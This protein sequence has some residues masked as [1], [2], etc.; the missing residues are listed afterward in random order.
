MVSFSVGMTFIYG[1]ISAGFAF[2]AIVWFFGI[3]AAL[4]DLGE[5]IAADSMDMQGDLLI[6]SNSIAIRYG[7]QAALRLSG[8]I[9]LM[10]IL[11]LFVPFLI[12]WFRIVHLMPIMIMISAIGYSA[13]RLLRS[14]NEEGRKY[15]RWIYLGSTLGLLIFIIMSL[16][17]V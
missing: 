17:G 8:F 1:G 12:G 5:E 15:I 7:R 16:F 9:F 11:L 13:L 6:N 2:N 4:I 10:V 14:K 3:I